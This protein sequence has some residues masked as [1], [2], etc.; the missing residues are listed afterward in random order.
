MKKK[1][2]LFCSAGMSTSLL[3][4]R[5]Q[6][7][8]DENNLPVEVKAFPYDSLDEIFEKDRPD[9]ILI[10]PQMRF[11]VDKVKQKYG[12][13]GVPV[14]AIDPIDY[15]RINAEK[16]LRFAVSLIKQAAKKEE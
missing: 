10:G 15:G 5:M 1:I 7:V 16:V 14:A 13:Q 6:K 9:C 3:S 8:G 2:Y 12:S 11:V 4:N